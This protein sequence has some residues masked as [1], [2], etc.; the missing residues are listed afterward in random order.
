MAIV[1]VLFSTN[2]ITVE[3]SA[4]HHLSQNEIASD[5]PCCRQLFLTAVISLRYSLIFT[6]QR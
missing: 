1:E 2:E 3:K 4:C 6:A 5:K